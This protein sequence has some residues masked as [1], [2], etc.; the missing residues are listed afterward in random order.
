M[1]LHAA[2][3]QV[4]VY[5]KSITNNIFL[6]IGSWKPLC[7][8]KINLMHYI[9]GFS[10]Q[11]H[12]RQRRIFTFSLKIL[13]GQLNGRK[14]IIWQIMWVR[15]KAQPISNMEIVSAFVCLRTQI[16]QFFFGLE[17]KK[18][19]SSLLLNKV[20]YY[21]CFLNLAWLLGV[22]TVWKALQVSL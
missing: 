1:N 11:P 9:T 19:K 15:A 10:C 18:Q 22:K 20:K 4:W 3:K 17:M 14:M 2:H 12:S 5:R 6:R 8:T 16:F 7:S 21:K 13:F